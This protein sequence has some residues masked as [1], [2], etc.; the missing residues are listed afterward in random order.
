M[1]STTKKITMVAMAIAI[2]IAGAWIALMLKLPIYLDSVGTI[3]SGMVF[4]PKYGMLAGIV[5][6]LVNG[7]YDSYAIY[8]MPVQ[9][10][11]GFLAGVLPGLKSRSL[12]KQIFWT[13]FL[14]LPASV[15]SALIVTYLFGTMSSSGSSYLVQFLRAFGVADFAA[16]FLTQVVTDFLDKWIAVFLN[17]KLIHSA[18]FTKFIP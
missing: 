17:N 11:L 9:M 2:N 10:V 13:F 8:F 16:V 14:S 7:T 1:N 12:K 6:A 4:G 15:T 5:T 18:Y 3:M